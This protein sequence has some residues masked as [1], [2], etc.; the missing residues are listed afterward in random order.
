MKTILAWVAM[1]SLVASNAFGFGFGPGGGSG[2]Q[3]PSGCTDGQM[4]MWVSATSTWDCTTGTGTGDMLAATYDSDTNGAVDVNNGGTNLTTM[5]ANV[6]T[7]LGAANYAAF[8]ESLGVGL[9]DTPSFA[10]LTISGAGG[11]DLGVAGSVQGDIAFYS[12]TPLNVF[13]AHIIGAN[14]TESYSL[15]LPTA[16]PLAAGS[17]LTFG[18][19]GTGSW[20]TPA[21]F[22]PALGADDNYVTDAEKTIIGNTSGANTGDQTATTVSVTA[23]GFD[24]NLATTD[25]T[26]Q[27]VAQ[28]L[29]D[30]VGAGMAYPGAGVPLSTGSAWDTSYTVGTGANNLV[31]LNA[32]SQI[33]AVSGA[34][35]TNLPTQISDTAYNATTWDAVTTAAPTKNA[36]RDYLE[37]VITSGSDG[38]YGYIYTNNTTRT[39]TAA[40]DENY[41]EGNIFKVNQNGTEST[42]AIGPLAGQVSFTGPTVA[43][44]Y[45]LPDAAATICTTN[46]VCSGYQASGSY[47]AS[48][49]D[50]DDLADGSL[51][52]TKVAFADTDGLWTAANVQAALEE[53]NDSINAGVP[54]GAGAKVHWSEITGMPAAF[55]D[56]TDDGA[57]SGIATVMEE[58]SALTQRATINFIG[59]AMTCADN[60]GSTRTDCTVA[61]APAADAVLTGSTQIPNGA[62]PTTDAAGEI[63][64]DSSTGA[65]QGV[66]AFGAIAFTLP[67]Y[68]TKCTTINAATASSDF[69]VDTFPYAITIRAAHVMQLGATNVIGHFDECDG[70]GANCATIDSTA[71]ITATTTMAADDGTLSNPSIDAADVIAWHTTS[72]SGTNTQVMVC[73]DYTVDQV[74]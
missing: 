41:F 19:T 39:P 37:S 22:A 70:N 51:T 13:V 67:A 3:M 49:A 47:Q 5:S 21:T 2:M 53:L 24:G 56:G 61:A 28:K 38:T 15:R 29:D 72:V 54:N 27:E 14:F 10:E 55:S 18:T 63:A 25:D 30:L 1:I 65:G 60:A 42:V 32:S 59:A 64:V 11:L 74:N 4:P 52:G 35:L 31:Q 17:L 7:L 43:R 12:N 6:L 66:R 73:I 23:T 68:Q 46:A 44:A 20:T 34:L 62:N 57:G 9:T 16:Y 48:D 33:P 58:G 50:L 26:V 8:L 40:T 71:D 69:M 36:I 45:A